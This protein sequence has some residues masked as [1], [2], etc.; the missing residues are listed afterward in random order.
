MP[1]K[2]ACKPFNGF[3][4]VGD[5]TLYNPGDFLHGTACGSTDNQW[6]VFQLSSQGYSLHARLRRSDFTE[7]S[8]KPC[9]FNFVPF[10]ANGPGACLGPFGFTKVPCSPSTIPIPD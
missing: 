6:I 4:Q 8:S 7:G 10:G 2:G 3:V 5:G 9:Y 1:F